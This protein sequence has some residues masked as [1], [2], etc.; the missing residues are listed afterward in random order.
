MFAELILLQMEVSMMMADHDAKMRKM[1]ANR[2]AQWQALYDAAG[3]ETRQL[4]LFQEGQRQAERRHK[5]M[6]TA[7]RSGRAPEVHHHHYTYF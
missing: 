4:M 5:E 6:L 7:A 1:E 3:P 2:V